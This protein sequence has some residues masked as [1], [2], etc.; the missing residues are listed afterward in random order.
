MNE[1]QIAAMMATIMSAMNPGTNSNNTAV[2]TPGK[3]KRPPVKVVMN[4]DTG[5]AITAYEK[6]PEFGFLQVEEAQVQMRSMSWVG[7]TRRTALIKGDVESL[8]VW[9]NENVK[10]GKLP[11]QIVVKEFQEDAV[12]EDIYREFIGDTEVRDYEEAVKPFVKRAGKEVDGIEAVP[13]TI[14]GSRILRF[15]FYDESG[16]MEDEKVQHDNGQDVAEQ[17]RQ[18]RAAAVLKM[19]AEQAEAIKAAAKETE[20][21]LA[22]AGLP[23]NEEDDDSIVDKEKKK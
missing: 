4:K 23:I 21:S 2:T 12:P 14:G 19:Q 13:L 5:L 22:G 10:A 18:R 16:E 1:Q 8:K 6:N 20:K 15:S 7:K 17:S 3:A 9:F 11:G